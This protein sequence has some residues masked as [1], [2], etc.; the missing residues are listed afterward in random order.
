MPFM[1]YDPI[2]LY[3]RWE[4]A[5]HCLTSMLFLLPCIDCFRLWFPFHIWNEL[6]TGSWN[7]ASVV[8]SQRDGSILTQSPDSS[9]SLLFSCF[10]FPIFK[11]VRSSW[12]SESE[13]GIE[14]SSLHIARIHR[15]KIKEGRREEEEEMR[16][17][18]V[19]WIYD[20]KPMSCYGVRLE[21]NVKKILEK[22]MSR[23]PKICL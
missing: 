15:K 6:Q 20:G 4:N 12:M 21:Q 1:P 18:S 2:S 3:R 8:G 17:A 9:P 5:I 13:W 10:P 19:Q 23:G 7:Y 16:I 22:K 11:N 14:Y